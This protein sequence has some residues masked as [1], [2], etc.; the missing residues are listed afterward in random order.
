MY[1]DVE[2]QRNDVYGCNTSSVPIELHRLHLVLR[3]A[4]AANPNYTIEPR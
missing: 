1:P 4:K 2:Q 3:S